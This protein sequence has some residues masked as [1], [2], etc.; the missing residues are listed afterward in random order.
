MTALHW[1]VLASRK[2]A[3]ARKKRLLS[4]GN[5]YGPKGAKRGRAQGDFSVDE[6]LARIRAAGEAP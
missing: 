4:C 3:E 1:R 5:G 6:L 2:G